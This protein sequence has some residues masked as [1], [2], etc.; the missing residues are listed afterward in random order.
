MHP[1]A[2]CRLPAS[3]PAPSSQLLALAAVFPGQRNMEQKPL[4]A[5]DS[6][7]TFILQ[8]RTGST[9]G[10]NRRSSA[11]F[12]DSD[13]SEEVSG[14]G[15][16]GPSPMPQQRVVAKTGTTSVAATVGGGRRILEGIRQSQQGQ[17]VDARWSNGSG[18]GRRRGRPSIAAER[19]DQQTATASV[20]YGS[21]RFPASRVALW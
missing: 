2:W 4:A 7:R 21:V 17:V 12:A 6:E 3:L 11:Y 20:F 19:G 1:P 10:R 14:T 16:A 13:A 18:V 15:T 9:P 5:T 8:R